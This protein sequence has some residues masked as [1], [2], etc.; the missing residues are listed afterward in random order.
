ML[1]IKHRVGFVWNI[2]EWA[3]G[4]LFTFRYGS[5]LK[6]V[7]G[8]ERVD[9][10]GYKYRLIVENDIDDLVSLAQ[11][12]PKK[13]FEWFNP[14]GFDKTSLFKQ[15]NNRAFL[16]YGCW[17]GEHLIGYHFLRCFFVGK[18]FRG[19]LVDV[20][21]QGRGIAKEMGRMHEE[22]CKRMG[23]RLFFTVSKENVASIASSKA[24]NNVKVI[25][26]LK[27]GYMLVECL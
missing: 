14:H 8:I 6:N 21:Y 10:N 15:F 7:N 16:M 12:Q 2:I 13:S 23:L 1:F 18:A 17:D 3:N 22:L 19:R 5:K 9:S 20:A 24:A 4:I 25:K 27:N 11:K 26:E